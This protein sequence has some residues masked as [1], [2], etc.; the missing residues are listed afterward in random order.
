MLKKLFSAFFR[1]NSFPC[2]LSLCRS[3][4]EIREIVPSSIF[5]NKTNVFHFNP[6]QQHQSRNCFR[7]DLSEKTKEGQLLVCL[8]I[9]CRTLPFGPTMA[10]TFWSP[11]HITLTQKESSSHIKMNEN[12]N[13]CKLSSLMGRSRRNTTRDLC[14]VRARAI[15]VVVVVVVWE[16]LVGEIENPPLPPPHDQFSFVHQEAR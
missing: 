14:R 12:V 15:V 4:N 11:G 2:I 5:H 16:L 6:L 9:F 13:S 1:T 8:K 10:G 3:H 7:A